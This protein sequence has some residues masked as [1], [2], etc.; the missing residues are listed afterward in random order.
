MG[1]GFWFNMDP[2]RRCCCTCT[3]SD[4][5]VRLNSARAEEMGSVTMC[6]NR[7]KLDESDLQEIVQAKSERKAFSVDHKGVLGNFFALGKVSSQIDVCD[8]DADDTSAPTSLDPSLMTVKTL[9]TRP[10]FLVSLK[11]KGNQWKHIGLTVHPDCKLGTLYIDKVWA[12]SLISSW[13]EAHP[14][15]QLCQGDSIGSVNGIAN[16]TEDDH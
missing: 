1:N 11:R 2:D 9:S 6:E 8:L 4:E 15:N 5:I 13:N 3:D 12:P 14:E 10:S 7:V 16:S